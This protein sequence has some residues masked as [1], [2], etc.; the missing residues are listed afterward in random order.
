MRPAGDLVQIVAVSHS[1]FHVLAS[2][3][4]QQSC[5]GD[6][7][8]LIATGRSGPGASSI[9]VWAQN[10]TKVRLTVELHVCESISNRIPAGVF[11]LEFCNAY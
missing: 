1:P 8:Y 10:T 2:N 5:E 7:C 3:L 6:G 4:I 9:K 11:S